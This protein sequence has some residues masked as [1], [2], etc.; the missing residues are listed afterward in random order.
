M[1]RTDGLRVHFFFQ[2]TISFHITNSIL[3]LRHLNMK[4]A[5]GKK[6]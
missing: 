5:L 2:V 6:Y 1:A 3:I 4:N